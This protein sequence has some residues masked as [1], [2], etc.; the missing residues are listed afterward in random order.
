VFV[1]DER[2][3]DGFSSAAAQ[4]NRTIDRTLQLKP[5]LWTCVQ[6]Q[7]TATR[8]RTFAV[9]VCEQDAQLGIV[10]PWRPTQ[11]A[12]LGFDAEFNLDLFHFNPENIPTGH[13][14]RGENEPAR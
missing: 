12:L 8:C 10:R 13:P 1:F 5:I 4:T 14:Q 9:L 3:A 2:T 6:A 11:P 7:Q